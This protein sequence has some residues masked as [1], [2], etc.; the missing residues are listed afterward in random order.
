MTVIGPLRSVGVTDVISLPLGVITRLPLASDSQN[1]V[2]SDFACATLS[3]GNRAASYAAS[4]TA[5]IVSFHRGPRC[6]TTARHDMKGGSSVT[7]FH[8]RS[9]RLSVTGTVS[10]SRL[11]LKFEKS[12]ME[13]ILSYSTVATISPP[14]SRE[15]TI[16]YDA[17]TCVT[18]SLF[19]DIG[20]ADNRRTFSFPSGVSHVPSASSFR[21]S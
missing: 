8:V 4:I 19:S 1:C 15:P 13:P 7:T 3:G 17:I 20:A 10:L 9:N 14:I 11:L 16:E 12:S 2:T 5:L 18:I 6:D 21:Y